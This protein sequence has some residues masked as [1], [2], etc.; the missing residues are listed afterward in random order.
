MT[1]TSPD[2]LSGRLVRAQVPDGTAEGRLLIPPG[3]GAIPL[4]VFYPDAGGIRP[5]TIEMGQRLV[6]AGYS[7]LEVDPFWRQRPYRPIDMRTAMGDPSER[8]RVL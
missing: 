8:A 2:S 5:S 4:V 3:R 7:V 6:A 1:A